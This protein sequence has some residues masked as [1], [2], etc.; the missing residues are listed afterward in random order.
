MTA[1][2]AVRPR[3]GVGTPSLP[4]RA[5]LTL[6]YFGS[7]LVVAVALLSCVYLLM[8]NL[9]TPP[10]APVAPGGGPPPVAA[11]PASGLFQASA[12]ALAVCGV[13]AL[14]AGRLMAGRALAPVNRVTATA[15][16]I[17]AGNLHQRVGLAGPDD[18]VKRLADTV[19]G[20]LSRLEAAFEAQRRFAA[21]ASHELLT[22]LATS[23]AILEVA[24]AHPER[25]DMS[26][27]TSKLLAVNERGERIVE[28]LLTLAWADYGGVERRDVDLAA[29]VGEAVERAGAEAEA[30]GVSV[31]VR[32]GA[33]RVDG[34]PVLL[35]RLADNLVVNAVRHNHP[36]GLVEVSSV[37]SGGAAT[38]TVSNT[39]AAVAPGTVGQLFEPFVR[40]RPRTQQDGVPG[41]GLGMA[42]IRAVAQAH[43]A[44]LTA[45]ANPEGGLTVCVRFPGPTR[46]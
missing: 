34:D 37:D 30:R 8:R 18:D 7:F 42:I 43:G 2:A 17:A 44:G 9:A 6:I 3:A 40:L 12:I 22:P 38:L 5:R 14:G 15:A 32:L 11:S 27:L 16:R 45:T 36:G 39:G 29:V 46:R 23:R 33:A 35:G 10:V 19:D 41:Q 21:N 24:A 1:P 31:R 28:A 4:I 26:E 13:I 20:M 25:C